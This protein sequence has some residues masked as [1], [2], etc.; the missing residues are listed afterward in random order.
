[1]RWYP[2]KEGYQKKLLWLNIDQVIH[3][4]FTTG[5]DGL[6]M[7]YL[8]GTNGTEL[9]THDPEDLEKLQQILQRNAC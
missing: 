1:M 9:T 3:I 7:A 2:L 5:S 6:P 8:V 4:R